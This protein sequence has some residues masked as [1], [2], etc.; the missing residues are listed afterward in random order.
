MAPGAPV[1]SAP[2]LRI[3]SP[4]P[5]PLTP[6]PTTHLDTH[7]FTILPAVLTPPALT[8]CTDIIAP[9]DT[10]S[11]TTRRGGVRNLLTRCPDLAPVLDDAGLPD[12]ASETLCARA[13]LTRAILFDKSP[14]ANW[15]LGWHQDT[16]IAVAERIDTPGFGPWSVKDGITHVRPPAHVLESM[17]TIRIH[18]DDTP[19]NNGALEVLPG[20]H[21]HAFLDDGRIDRIAADTDPVVCACAA[22]DALLMRPLLLHRSARSRLPAARRRVVHLEYASAPR[23]GHRLGWAL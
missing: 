11:H 19:A 5:H 22:G 13:H 12:L 16:T 17:L 21:R 20:S 10:A 4:M 6:P 18:L 8:A 9:L 15:R 23:A 1:E 2:S 7:G 3:P 14:D